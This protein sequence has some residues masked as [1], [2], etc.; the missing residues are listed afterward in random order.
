MATV[1]EAVHDPDERLVGEVRVVDDDHHRT[2][3]RDAP[4]PFDELVDLVLVVEPGCRRR[5][6][7]R[8]PG[9]H[10]PQASP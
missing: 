10:C 9:A 2:V 4:E 5:R 1:R 7:V 6:L 3:T 8:R